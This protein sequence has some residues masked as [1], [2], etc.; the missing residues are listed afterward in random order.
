MDLR[1]VLKFHGGSVTP[2]AYLFQKK[3]RIAFEADDR[4][5]GVDDVLDEAIEAGAEDV[6]ADDSGSIVVW[7]EP[8]MTT[9][10]IDTLGKSLNLKVESSDIIWDPNEDTMCPLEEGNAAQRLRDAIEALQDNSAVQG[11]YTNAAQGTLSDEL[12][13]EIQ[14]QL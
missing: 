3:G 9:S 11:V 1:N 13:D 8:S 6:E 7:T 5:L 4:K 14:G 2:T 10:A 12:W